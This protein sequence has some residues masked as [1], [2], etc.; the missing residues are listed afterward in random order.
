M[1]ASRA[2]H[3]ADYGWTVW[4]LLFFRGRGSGRKSGS[5]ARNGR[6]G[7]DALVLTAC[8]AMACTSLFGAML[9]DAPAKVARRGPEANATRGERGPAHPDARQH[10]HR[11][12]LSFWAP[13]PATT[14]GAVSF[15]KKPV[16]ARSCF[17]LACGV[18]HQV[19][20]RNP[21][22]TATDGQT[23]DGAPA[24]DHR[25][26]MDRRRGSRQSCSRI[27][28]A[29]H[30]QAAA[31]CGIG[32]L[33][34]FIRGHDLGLSDFLH[35]LH[36]QSIVCSLDVALINYDVAGEALAVRSMSPWH[37]GKI[38]RRKL[39]A[40]MESQNESSDTPPV[41]C[42]GCVCVNQS[43]SVDADTVTVMDTSPEAAVLYQSER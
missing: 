6:I 36:A 1:A 26:H 4:L 23:A 41:A 29:V 25:G 17:P 30:L 24:A 42:P 15:R 10:G 27:R 35:F 32:H 38:D 2:L 34:A 21:R 18:W 22:P 31:S 19:K 5:T 28:H 9:E 33:I 13:S 3:R 39:L 12:L 7:A 16:S 20:P 8:T 37:D 43:A 11:E 14:A 40:W